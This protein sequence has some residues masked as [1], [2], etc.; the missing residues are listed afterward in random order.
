[1]NNL[2]QFTDK[3]IFAMATSKTHIIN[4]F[5]CQVGRSKQ[6][7]NDKQYTNIQK[8]NALETTKKKDTAA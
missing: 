3:K 6:K 4:T 5:I 7:I 2:F 8:H 1:M